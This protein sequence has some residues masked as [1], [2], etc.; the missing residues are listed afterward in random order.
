MGPRE[1]TLVL[2]GGP[3]IVREVLAAP[4][5]GYQ[6]IRVQREGRSGD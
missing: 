5:P 4:P 2:P 3:V 6:D 1:I